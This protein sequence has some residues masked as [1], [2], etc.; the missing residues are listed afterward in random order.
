MHHAF[1]QPS[2]KPCLG[3]K[4]VVRRR[5]RGNSVASRW[6]V[7]RK[8]KVSARF[9]SGVCLLQSDPV[10]L[11]GGLNAYMYARANPLKYSDSAGLVST[12]IV[13]RD[14]GRAGGPISSTIGNHVALHL[15]RG[16]SG[17]P[18]L[19]DPGGSYV[20]KS[21][22]DMG[23]GRLTSGDDAS[24][25]D[26]VKQQLDLGSSVELIPIPTTASQEADIAA[27]AEAQG[28]TGPFF[29]AV[30]VS[31]ALGGVCGIE[32]GLVPSAV[33]AAAAS[34]QCQSK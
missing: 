16:I 5:R 30:G 29:C 33:G 26:Y 23:S 22:A 32:P 2:R 11:A 18:T 15:D 31:G 17:Q 9:A 8:A 6:R 3:A 28:D 12:I 7:G 25:T 4:N 19:Y 10:G 1:D 14:G 13:V 20:P 24:L 27:R 34:A 21:G